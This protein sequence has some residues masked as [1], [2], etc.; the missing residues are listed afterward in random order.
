LSFENRELYVPTG[1]CGG[2]KEARSRV[3]ALYRS[4]GMVLPTEFLARDL[5]DR[6]EGFEG[7]G[8]GESGELLLGGVTV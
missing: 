3:D 8:D 6:L 1:V 2:E 7:F 4:S 5:E